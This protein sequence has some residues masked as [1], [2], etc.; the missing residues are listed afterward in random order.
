M[1]S[2]SPSPAD[3][4]TW[5]KGS[6]P[7]PTPAPGEDAVRHYF[8]S[9]A[10]PG[11]HSPS[12]INQPH[13]RMY[14]SAVTLQ[15]Q[16]LPPASRRMVPCAMPPPGR[17]SLP[18]VALV[19]ALAAAAA[20]HAA[21]TSQQTH[22]SESYTGCSWGGYPGDHAGE[23]GGDEAACHTYCIRVCGAA[24]VACTHVHGDE[25]SASA[26]VAA[27]SCTFPVG[28]SFTTP[29]VVASSVVGTRAVGQ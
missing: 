17:Y 20:A 21:L 10:R 4:I 18:A 15:P 5:H 13:Y 24:P 14:V 29:V 2:D 1:G 27:A 3:D 25:T 22:G 11:S 26:L 12:L 9:R 23:G 16:S 28:R 8:S 19:V 6:D 7:P